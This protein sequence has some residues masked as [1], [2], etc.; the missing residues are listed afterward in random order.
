MKRVLLT[1]VAICAPAAAWAQQGDTR[2]PAEGLIVPT[3]QTAASSA[4]AAAVQ[5]RSG[6][7]GPSLRPSMAGFIENATIG[8]K[9]RVR[10]DSGTGLQGGDRA[11]FFYA[12]CGCYRSLPTTD[13]AYDPDAPGPGPAKLTRANYTQFNV[14][15]EYAVNGRFSLVADLPVRS[16]KPQ[17]F[18]PG[19]GT[20]G[21]SSGVGDVKGGV[22]L[23]MSS[24]SNS[25]ITFQALASA[26]TGDA[27][28]GLGTN[29]WT[30]E[31]AI[32]YSTTAGDLLGFEVQFGSIIPLDGSKAV[33]TG[34]P[35]KFSGSIIYYGFGPSL[36]IYSGGSTRLAPVVELVGWHVVDGYSTLEGAPAK[37]TDIINLKVG[38]R[39]AFGSGSLY[40]GWGK[41]LTDAAWYD[42]LVRVEFRYGF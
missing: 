16:L 3:V 13:A 37:G 23:S 33:P 42:E 10:F 8:S 28:M 17:A 24:D 12:K 39:L 6:S 21:D 9:L 19:T 27:A 32:L 11:E 14:T 5:A 7:S 25:Q 4:N 1:L 26:P 2:E 38:G 30:V 20:F 41:A 29:H 18:A 22:K 36:D 31:P 15:T 35:D 40:A 34:G